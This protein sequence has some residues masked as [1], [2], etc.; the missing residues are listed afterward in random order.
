MW[1]PALAHVIRS[2]GN[3][4]IAMLGMLLSTVINLSLDPSLIYVMDFG[5]V[6]AVGATAVA[7]I[8]ST[9]FYV[10]M[11]SRNKKSYLSLSVKDIKL[12]GGTALGIIAIGIPASVSS[13]L[14]SISTMIY[15]IFL[16][17]YGNEAVAAM[18]IV[19]KIILMYTMV[20]MGIAT[21]G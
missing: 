7:N 11:I 4:K 12:G 17:P 18:G 1:H 10:I 16:L 15:N 9:L 5:V 8:V 2:E 13:L 21:G 20:F 3:A 14:T 6:G 19:M